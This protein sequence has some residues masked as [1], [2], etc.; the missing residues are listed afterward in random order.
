MDFSSG[1][2]FG[3]MVRQ[4]AL[5]ELSEDSEGVCHIEDTTLTHGAALRGRQW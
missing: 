3:G 1:N 2:E 4:V 5:V